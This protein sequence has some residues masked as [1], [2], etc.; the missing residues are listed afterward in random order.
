MG[1]ERLRFAHKALIYKVNV[2]LEDYHNGEIDYALLCDMMVRAIYKYEGYIDAL[3]DALVL[4]WSSYC[5]ARREIK[6]IRNM[7]HNIPRNR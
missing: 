7:I 3:A 6:Y 4:D 2:H 1:K 5:K